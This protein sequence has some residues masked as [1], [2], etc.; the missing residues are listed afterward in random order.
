MQKHLDRLRNREIYN[1]Q[2]LVERQV[3]Q[4][5]TFSGLR[6]QEGKAGK[7]TRQLTYRMTALRKNIN[8]LM[9]AWVALHV[10]GTPATALPEYDETDILANILPWQHTASQEGGASRQQL[11]RQLYHVESE[12]TCCSEEQVVL[13]HDAMRCLFFTSGR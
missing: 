3:H 2:L 9:S 6:E 4:M 8:D 11:E 12:E 1:M 10:L 13:P 5:S 7:S